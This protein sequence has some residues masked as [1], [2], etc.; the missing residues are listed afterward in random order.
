MVSSLLTDIYLQSE[1]LEKVF[2]GDT[3]SYMVCLLDY[4]CDKSS[5][6]KLYLKTLMNLEVD[7]KLPKE[8]VSEIKSLIQKAA[9]SIQAESNAYLNSFLA[10]FTSRPSTIRFEHEY[11]ASAFYLLAPKTYAFKG[12]GK[13]TITKKNFGVKRTDPTFIKENLELILR[14]ILIDASIEHLLPTLVKLTLEAVKRMENFDRSISIPTNINKSVGGYKTFTAQLKGFLNFICVKLI[15]KTHFNV[16]IK[17]NMTGSNSGF[18]FLVNPTSTLLTTYRSIFEE[19]Y[20]K[21]SIQNKSV[22]FDES[23]LSE[24]FIPDSVYHSTSSATDK[25]QTLLDVVKTL[26]SINVYEMLDCTLYSYI[27]RLLDCRPLNKFHYMCKVIFDNAS[28]DRVFDEIDYL[29][30]LPY[31]KM[32]KKNT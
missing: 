30:L 11:D 14:K 21:F 6:S 9:D 26:F 1:S 12:L 25:G 17:M 16:D 19:V 2:Y 15:A 29:Q 10:R 5:K 32:A 18:R 31:F 27:D 8:D 13:N 3:D 7:G 24:L 28:E 23:H 20:T 4:I 22:K